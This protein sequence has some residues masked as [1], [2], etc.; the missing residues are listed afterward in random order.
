MKLPIIDPK[1][2]TLPVKAPSNKPPREWQ[3]HE[4][5]DGT[6]IM[7]AGRDPDDYAFGRVLPICYVMAGETEVENARLIA[8]APDLLDALKLAV[9]RDRSL[10]YNAMIMQALAK[11]EPKQ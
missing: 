11:A 6:Y 3:I 8:A 7:P 1:V 2:Q 9:I 10:Q 4:E 5:V